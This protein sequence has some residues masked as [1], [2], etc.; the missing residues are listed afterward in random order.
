MPNLMLSSLGVP[1]TYPINLSIR[2]YK[3]VEICNNSTLYAFGSNDR[4]GTTSLTQLR[5]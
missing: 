4:E 3:C 1:I 2:E 5:Q